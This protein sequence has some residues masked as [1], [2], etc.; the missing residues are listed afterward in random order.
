MIEPKSSKIF[1]QS[2]RD[3]QIITSDLTLP[4][5]RLRASFKQ[6][7]WTV[8]SVVNNVVLRLN[9]TKAKL[10]CYPQTKRHR[11]PAGE[12]EYKLS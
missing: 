4:F 7:E 11:S 12:T 2:S 9:Q 5:V 10:P 3:S 8:K 6:Q 1:M